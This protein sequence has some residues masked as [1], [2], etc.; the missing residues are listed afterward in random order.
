MKLLLYSKKGSNQKLGD[1]LLHVSRRSQIRSS[2][3][4]HYPAIHPRYLFVT[5]IS[6]KDFFFLINLM[7][8]LVYTKV[9]LFNQFIY[10][11]TAC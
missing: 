3:N 6:M 2:G 9:M 8:I 10:Y 4:V 5:V 11:L 1:L 7:S